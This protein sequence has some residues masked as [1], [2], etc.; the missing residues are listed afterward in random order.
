M[1]EG[2][3]VD[4]FFFLLVLLFFFSFSKVYLKKKMKIIIIIDIKNP[5]QPQ[6]PHNGR[7]LVS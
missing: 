6:R 5:H 7:H 3:N 1:F 4:V 2:G